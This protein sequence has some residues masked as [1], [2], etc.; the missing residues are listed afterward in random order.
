MS[1]AHASISGQ[2]RQIVDRDGPPTGNT[3]PQDRSVNTAGGDAQV[4]TQP[5]AMSRSPVCNE[6]D[7]SSI[8][9]QLECDQ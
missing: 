2:T 3:S 1:R 4:E 9:E 8:A 5:S 7:T 6:L